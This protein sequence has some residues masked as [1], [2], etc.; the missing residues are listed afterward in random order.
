MTACDCCQR[1]YQAFPG[2]DVR[3]VDFLQARTLAHDGVRG[4]ADCLVTDA[5]Q[6]L[7]LELERQSVRKGSIINQVYLE[8]N[9]KAMRFAYHL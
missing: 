7:D 6:N 2:S 9:F 5:I 3:Q 1:A 8:L 4:R